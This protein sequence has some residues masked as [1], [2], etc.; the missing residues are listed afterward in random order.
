MV[1]KYTKAYMHKNIEDV[2]KKAYLSQS[3][4]K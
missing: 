2:R 3:E 4:Y 1:K